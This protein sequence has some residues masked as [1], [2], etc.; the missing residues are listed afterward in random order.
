MFSLWLIWVWDKTGIDLLLTFGVIFM[1]G[2]ILGLF[3]YSCVAFSWFASEHKTN[4]INREF[5]TN[6]TRNEVFYAQDVIEEIQNINRNRYEING[7]LFNSRTLD[8]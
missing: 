1:I 6:Y 3:V 2:A 8:K 7:N 5:G 4:I